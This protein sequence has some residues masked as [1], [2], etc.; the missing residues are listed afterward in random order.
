MQTCLVAGG[1]GFIGSHL[2]DR[3]IEDGYRVVCVDN[4]LTGN[5]DN[6]AHL[7][8]KEE[9][10]FIEAD[11]TETKTYEK[12]D[13]KYD[14][15]FHLAS[16][17]SPNPRSQRSY[18]ALPLETMLANSLGTKLLLDLAKGQNSRCLFAST[19]EVYGDPEEHP[20]KETYWGHVNSVGKR[21]CYDESKRFGEA[22]TMVYLRQGVDTRIAR[23][24]NTYGPR[25]NPEDGRVV[26]DFVMQALK[27]KPFII[28][29]NGEQTRSF[30]YV[31][32]MVE[33]LTRLMFNDEA[34]GKVV[35][36]GNPNEYSINQLMGLVADKVRVSQET[37][38]VPLPEDDPQRRQPD[39]SLAKKL[40]SWEP[41]VSLDKGL[42]K[43]IEFFREV[44]RGEF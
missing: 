34:K 29:G 21:A 2:W 4:L 5:R 11:I 30:C 10:V 19:S 3:L 23:I 24:F 1:A 36:L 20:Q 38:R 26:I 12:L 44:V 42:D 15:I 22:I 27:A 14:F 31:T 39:I 32:D 17:A 28:H 9:F 16:P 7:E 6:I 37:E 25:M 13:G 35:N 41:E 8:S 33:G 40:L 18:L 43:T